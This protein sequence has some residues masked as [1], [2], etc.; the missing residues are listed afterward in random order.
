MRYF[1]IFKPKWS[2][3]VAKINEKIRKKSIYLEKIPNQSYEKALSKQGK[4]RKNQGPQDKERNQSY[5]CGLQQ[6]KTFQ[7]RCQLD[8]Q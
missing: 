8:G 4:S 6:K 5:G 1:C 7:K 3:I 2:D